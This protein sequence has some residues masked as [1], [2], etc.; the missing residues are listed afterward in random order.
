M[1]SSQ[2]QRLFRELVPFVSRLPLL[3]PPQR[4]GLLVGEHHGDQTDAQTLP[5]GDDHPVA[6]VGFQAGARSASPRPLSETRAS[7]LGPLLHIQADGVG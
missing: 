4:F 6:K 7:L 1:K 5:L 2:K 3:L